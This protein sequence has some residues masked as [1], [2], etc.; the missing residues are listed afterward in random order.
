MKN[1]IKSVINL[2]KVNIRYS[3]TPGVSIFGYNLYGDIRSGVNKS[4]SSYALDYVK[5]L[6]SKHVLDVG[7]GGGQHAKEFIDNGSDVVC[8]D[9]GTSIYAKNDDN[10]YK[11]ISLVN[12]DFKNFTSD[13]K[14]DLVW[15]SHI[16]EHQRDVGSFIEKII[17][18]CDDK[19][20]ACCITVPDPHRGLWGGHL[21][22][23][24]PGLLAY[25]IVL[26]GVDL[27]EAIF[28]RGTDEFS[29]FFILKRFSLPKDLT[30]DSG[31]IKKLTGYFPEG[32]K[33]NSD[34]WAV[35]YI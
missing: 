23:W 33:E 29:I 20:G 12:V 13:K 30:F 9:F 1:F 3:I 34:P 2:F 32:M 25:N 6:K 27:S 16:L 31:D 8:V 26:C 15:A 22:L 4:R 7:S 21:T 35:K 24:T 19:G 28:I 5:S 17:S 14:F 18:H 11:N 10:N